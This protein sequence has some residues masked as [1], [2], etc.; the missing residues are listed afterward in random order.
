MPS[1]LQSVRDAA[2]DLVVEDAV[3][4]WVAVLC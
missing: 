1:V 3:A 4:A 2:V